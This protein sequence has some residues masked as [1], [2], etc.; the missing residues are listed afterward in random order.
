MNRLSSNATI[1]ERSDGLLEDRLHILIADDDPMFRKILTKWTED[2]DCTVSVATNGDEAWDILQKEMAP[3]LLIL[4]WNMP[5]IDGL[6]LCRRIRRSGRDPYQYILLVTSRDHKQDVVKGLDSGADDY[7]TKPFDV[8]ELKARVRVGR[9]FLTLQKELIQSRESMRF[10][11]TH[12]ALTSVWNRGSILEFLAAELQRAE[13][14][15]TTTSVVMVDIDHFK[16]VNDTYGHP[17]GDTVL[18]EIAVR[19]SHSV[20]TYDYIG[21]YGGEEF[22]IVLPSCGKDSVRHCAERIRRA[23]CHEPI[24]TQSGMVPVT[25]SIGASVVEAGTVAPEAVLASADR[26]LYRAKKAGR[27]CAVA[28]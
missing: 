16:A 18:T 11:A 20:R 25:V 7:I 15:E 27:N 14:L 23:A 5:G 6:E 12:D 28:D 1:V 17:T 13:R 4:D 10:H 22:L 26:A 3:H 19:I 9:R 8:H 24:N 2:N 21:R